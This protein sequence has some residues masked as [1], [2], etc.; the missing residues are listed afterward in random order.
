MLIGL[1]VAALVGLINGLLIARIRLSPFV[2]TLGMLSIC[3]GITYV[4]TQGRGQ[5]PAGPQ[6]DTFYALTDGKIFGLPVPLVYL[7]V[8]ARRHGRRA[9]P[10]ALGP[11][12]LRARRQRAGRA[13]H[14]RR[15]RPGQDLGLRAVRA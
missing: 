6:V 8:L 4:I 3:R 12:R 10:H 2:T 14:R 9:A 11:L 7:L 5:A 15:G 13:A 1:A